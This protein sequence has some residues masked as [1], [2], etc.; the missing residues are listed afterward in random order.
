MRGRARTTRPRGS[1]WAY[2]NGEGAGR[3]TATDSRGRRAST[4]M[5]VRALVLMPTTVNQLSYR[6]PADNELRT[7][8]SYGRGRGTRVNVGRMIDVGHVV[9]SSTAPPEAFF[10]RWIELETHPEWAASMEW[11]QL[12]EPVAIGA[13]GTLKSKT[14]EPLPFRVT[15]FERPYVYADTTELDGAELTVHHEARPTKDGCRVELRAWLEGPRAADLEL[16]FRANVQRALEADVRALVELVEGR[17]PDL[18]ENSAV[19][20]GT[21]IDSEVTDGPAD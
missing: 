5:A 12:D 19:T 6:R 11:F 8:P 4:A 3:V 14:G 7:E 9:V 16:E 21:V 10:E 17:R 13:R 2:I 18:S 20:D 1:P 15:A